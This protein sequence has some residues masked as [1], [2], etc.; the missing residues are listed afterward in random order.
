MPVSALKLIKQYSSTNT[1]IDEILKVQARRAHLEDSSG[2]RGH[3]YT[4]TP[5]PR[6]PHVHCARAR[7]ARRVIDRS[8]TR[9]EGYER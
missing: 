2:R 9:A 3:A 1:P 5:R 4:L 7:N 6:Q 8:A